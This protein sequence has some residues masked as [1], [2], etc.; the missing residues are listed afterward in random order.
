M[1]QAKDDIYKT[2]MKVT[3]GK[4]PTAKDASLKVPITN[5]G[6]LEGKKPD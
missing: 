2:D 5:K 3:K 6:S 4:E 1:K